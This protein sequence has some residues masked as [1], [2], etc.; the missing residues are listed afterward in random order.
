MYL[1]TFFFFFIILYILFSPPADALRVA[2]A[3]LFLLF[4]PSCT[5]SQAVPV[6]LLNREKWK[7]YKSCTVCTLYLILTNRFYHYW[8][9]HNIIYLITYLFFN[10]GSI[11]WI[12]I[13]IIIIITTCFFIF[14]GKFIHTNF[15]HVLNENNY[16]CFRWILLYCFFFWVWI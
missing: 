6:V 4:S 15:K 7:P 5:K 3:V 2:I 8:S 1:R 10:N 9:V 14:N 12:L 13:I 11:V 16:Y